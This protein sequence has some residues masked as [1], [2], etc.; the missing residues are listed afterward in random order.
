MAVTV[1]LAIPFAGAAGQERAT[2][3]ASIAPPSSP[4]S[5]ADGYL[6]PELA[7]RPAM[8]P[9]RVTRSPVIDGRLD[10]PEWQGAALISG[11]RQ[12]LP[13]TGLPATFPTVVRVLYDE[14]HLYIG[15]ENMDPEPQRAITAGLE[16]DFTSSDSDLFGMV[17]DTFLDRR[18]AFLFLVNPHGAVRDE[19]VFNDSRTVVDAWEGIIQVRTRMTDSS[20][21]AEIAIPL[22]SLRFDGS[23]PVQDWGANFIRRVRRVNETSY[24]AP[25]ERQYRLHRMSKAGTLQGLEGLRSGRNLQIK[26]Y[27]V[28]GDSRGAQVPTSAQ[29]TSQDAG[30][31]LKYGV[32]PSMTLDA[33]YNTDFS[34]V[35]VDQEQV[36]LTRFSLFFPER[37]EFFIENA[38]SFTFGDVEERNYRMGAAL[39]DF[40]LFNSRQIG[41]TGDGRPI[42]IIGGGRLTGRAG[43]WELGLLEMQTQ[44]STSG[45]AENFGVLRARRNLWGNSDVG[46]LVQRRGAIDGS[47]SENVSYGV[48]A[49][50][51]PVGNLII[52]AY[53]A[54]SEAAG[55]LSD[56]HA[57]RVSVAY[58]DAF[59]NTSAMVKQVSDAFDPG[60][61]FVRRRGMQQAFATF[62]VHTRPTWRGIQEVAPYVSFDHIADERGQLDTRTVEAGVEVQFRPDGKITLELQDQFDRLDAPF[63]PVTGRAIPAGAYG[64]REAT[65]SWES[66]RARP[67]FWKADATTG[68]FYDG[69]RKSYGTTVTWRA[70]Y[71]LMVEANYTRNDVTL[72]SGPFQADVGR[73][74]LRY[75]WST[76][77]FGSAFVQ[78]NAQSNTMVTN[79]RVNFRYAPLSDIFLV[80]TDRRN[81][82]TG[83]LGE[84]TLALKVTRMLAF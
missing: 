58:R 79:A 33:T 57:E 78:Y 82:E 11:F 12:Q 50:L 10:E 81:Q 73:L 54:A 40:T 66:S 71:D 7:P 64:W 83:V 70:R 75:A 76:R 34:Q 59:F 68:G 47:G 52:N 21:I 69:S 51:R 22:R 20:W 42:P 5:A 36:N 84:R 2:T 35:E 26:P 46:A 53:A 24:W 67:V 1:A 38:G 63:S 13:R 25:L 15:A 31:D 72:A 43:P 30:L 6:D 60:L 16:R 45:A 28:G 39:R 19:Q 61:G 74:R 29:G 44:R 9:T 32:T 65:M 37:R 27:V 41:L 62:G 23:K 48:D 77:L 3:P 80:Y 14:E 56:G 18:N 17:F 49:N 4:S 55:R 8:H